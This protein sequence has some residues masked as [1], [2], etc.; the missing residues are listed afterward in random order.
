MAPGGRYFFTRNAST[1]VG[2]CSS[3]LALHRSCT[4]T[5]CH[6]LLHG[7]IEGV[8]TSPAGPIAGTAA[9]TCSMPA[10]GA[11]GCH[12]AQ[13]A[14]AVGAKYQPGNGFM[15]VG[16]HTDRRDSPACKVFSWSHHCAAAFWSRACHGMEW[17]GGASV[18]AWLG[19]AWHSAAR[20]LTLLATL[21]ACLPAAALA[22]SSNPSAA[23]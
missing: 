14:F 8:E 13:V 2:A 1:L 20:L 23:A 21:H 10:A 4:Y 15:M 5:A 3:S 12:A 16:A 7:C 11:G 6:W 22:S 18:R 9:A 19:A 17:H